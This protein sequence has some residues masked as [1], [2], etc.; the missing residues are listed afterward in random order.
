MG[1]APS[2]GLSSRDRLSQP[3]LYHL[4]AFAGGAPSSEQWCSPSSTQIAHAPACCFWLAALST[5]SHSSK[6]GPRSAAP[7][8]PE[9]HQEC[10]L[11]GPPWTFGSRICLFNEEYPM[12]PVPMNIRDTHPNCPPLCP[13]V[14]TADFWAF[15]TTSCSW[16]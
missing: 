8:H 14:P 13:T 4:V 6:C 5:K 15:P 9:A 2:G 3:L 7:P 10:R 1:Q 12:N 16:L 11:S